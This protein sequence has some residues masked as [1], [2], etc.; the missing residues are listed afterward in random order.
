LK[1]REYARIAAAVTLIESVHRE[2]VGQAAMRKSSS[3]STGLGDLM[4][5]ASFLALSVVAGAFVALLLMV[6]AS[7]VVAIFPADSGAKEIVTTLALL[8]G[9]VA[10][11][12]VAVFTIGPWR[13]LQARARVERFD[14]SDALP[15]EMIGRPVGTRR[16]ANDAAANDMHPRRVVRTR[17]QA[18]EDDRDDALMLEEEAEMPRRN[19]RPAPPRHRRAS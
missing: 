3:S 2:P 18:D 4:I 17:F 1:L 10:G 19:R 6:A 13:R 16:V 11:C 8:W 9:V 15:L 14:D 5:F 12:V 7:P